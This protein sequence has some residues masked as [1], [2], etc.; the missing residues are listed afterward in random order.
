MEDVKVPPKRDQ[1]I[2]ISALVT[3]IVAKL[4]FVRYMFFPWFNYR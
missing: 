1:I 3:M 4:Y 2:Q